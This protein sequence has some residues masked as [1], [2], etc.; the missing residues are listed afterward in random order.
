MS[1]PPDLDAY[2]GRIGYVGA[3]TPT[4][5]TLRNLVLH[6]VR[7][8]AFESVDPFLG[9]PVSLALADIE[10]KLVHGRRGGY[11][12]EHN[13]LFGAVLR[14]L[15]FKVTTLSARVL[16][17]QPEDATVPRAHMLLKVELGDAPLIVDVGFGGQ[18]PTCPL[19]LHTDLPQPTPHGHCRLLSDEQGWRLQAD[20]RGEW[21]T[22]YR[23]GIEPDFP[24]DYEIANYYLS[25]HPES[26]FVSNLIA[27]RA[28]AQ[29]RLACTT[30]TTR[31]TARMA[32]P[33]AAGWKAPQRSGKCCAANSWW[34]CRIPP[35]AT[36]NWTRFPRGQRRSHVSRPIILRSGGSTLCAEHA[37]ATPPA[38]TIQGPMETTHRLRRCL[39]WLALCAM[40]LGVFAPVVSQWLANA[41]TVVWVHICSEAGAAPV[42]IAVSHGHSPKAPAVGDG[43]CPY[44]TL[45]QHWPFAPPMSAGSIPPPQGATLAYAGSA[46]PSPSLAP[47]WH[48]HA[49]R[50][51]PLLS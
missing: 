11:C 14:A 37:G 49:P 26:P 1:K 20:V 33:C 23:F 41:R 35:K 25:T 12:Y 10:Q 29:G 22:L 31:V 38:T 44:C 47:R 24:P 17:G 16:W 27:A 39:A 45:A 18:T 40:C 9:R 51:P 34:N 43:Y 5:D 13:G 7:T 19:R 8:I 46:L 2:F 15:G 28:T 30:G 4:A 42:A 21:R 3:A 50:A 48:A 36:V 6:H 32:A